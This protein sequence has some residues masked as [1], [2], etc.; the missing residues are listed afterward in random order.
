[1]VLNY[2]R[3][4]EGVGYDLSLF[5]A[6]TPDERAAIETILLN[7]P[8]TDWRPVEAL[9]AMHTPQCMDKLK[10][11]F[12]TSTD[13]EVKLAI[14]QY[15][16]EIFSHEQRSAAIISA[17]KEATLIK[18]LTAA[19]RQIPNF[20]PPEVIA[21]LHHA[22][23]HREGESAIHCAAMLLFLHGKAAS[24]FDNA[25]MAFLTRFCLKAPGERVAAYEELCRRI[26]DS[27]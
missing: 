21:Q 23:L 27:K 17:L 6:A 20:H 18:G 5:R 24:I 16:G 13:H 1:M 3:W 25:H 22:A 19:L 26:T 12:A 9:H 4:H 11:T 10:S 8:I 15:A 7:E 14:T 2:E